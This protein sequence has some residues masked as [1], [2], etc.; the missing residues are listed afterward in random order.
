MQAF[1]VSTQVSIVMTGNPIGHVPP[2]YSLD[3]AAFVGFISPVDQPRLKSVLYR[4]SCCIL[5]GPDI[6]LRD[7][8]PGFYLDRLQAGFFFKEQIALHTFIVSPEIKI[9][10]L[11]CIVAGFE[12]LADNERL[13]ECPAQRV[14]GEKL[15]RTD[16]E[17][18]AGKASVDEVKFWRFY[19]S[20]AEIFVVWRQ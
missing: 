1:F 18:P 16:S 9:S 14:H 10:R 2:S 17:K 8:F 3:A 20:F 11:A 5:P 13:K 12:K 19:Q 7:S 15:G 4:K 6:I